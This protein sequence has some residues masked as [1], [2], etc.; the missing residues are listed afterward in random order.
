MAPDKMR[1][2]QGYQEMAM[3]CSGTCDELPHN[4]KLVEQHVISRNDSR[5]VVIDAAAFKSKNLYN[6]ALNELRQA[7]IFQ[8]KYIPYNDLDKLI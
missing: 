7:F 3:H 5:F 8:G 2:Q 6:A 1:W 4:M